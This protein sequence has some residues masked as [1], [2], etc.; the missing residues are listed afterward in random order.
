MLISVFVF[1]SERRA[2]WKTSG[3]LNLL[4]VGGCTDANAVRTYK[5]LFEGLDS[6]VS[7]RDD[8]CC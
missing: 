2:V 5:G 8:N 6:G 3:R 1:R 4:A 7:G